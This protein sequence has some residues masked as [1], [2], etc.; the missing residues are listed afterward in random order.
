[1]EYPA[2][3]LIDRLMNL[4]QPGDAVW[5]ADRPEN[6]YYVAVLVERSVPTFEDFRKIYQNA[7]SRIGQDPMWNFFVRDHRKEFQD[8]FIHRMREE[9]AGELE[10]GKYKVDAEVRARYEKAEAQ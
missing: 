10:N 5:F 1:M 3:N 9:A 6:H 7:E 8:Q 2:S 4:Q